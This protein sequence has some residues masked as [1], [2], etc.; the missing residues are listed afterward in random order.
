MMGKW[1]THTTHKSA[2]SLA[3][4]MAETSSEACKV[5]ASHGYYRAAYRAE[6]AAPHTTAHILIIITHHGGHG[7]LPPTLPRAMA[8]WQASKC[9][10]FP[11]GCALLINILTNFAWKID[12]AIFLEP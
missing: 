10:E 9:I 4:C 3:A 11:V 7:D 6:P 8:P 2:R 1:G 5:R 12:F